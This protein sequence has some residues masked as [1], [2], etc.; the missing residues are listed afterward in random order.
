[1]SKTR[2]EQIAELQ[3]DWSTNRRWA[4]VKR[5]YTAEDVIRLRGSKTRENTLARDG[6]LAERRRLLARIG[7]V[8]CAASLGR[9]GVV[10]VVL[11]VGPALRLGLT[12]TLGGGLGLGLRLPS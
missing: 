6:A 9:E 5:G 4:N 10:R 8:L 11:G 3:Q 2:K 7:A 12:P 1:M